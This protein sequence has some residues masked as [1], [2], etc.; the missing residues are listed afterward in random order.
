MNAEQYLKKVK[1]VK[2]IK[3]LKI[4]LLASR[5][6]IGA[7]CFVSVLSCFTLEWQA[8]LASC[9]TLFVPLGAA[10]LI[11]N[12]IQGIELYVEELRQD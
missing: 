12:Q 5:L 11:K 6:G 3:S 7:M 1:A 8:V 4:E 2:M 9:L 10:W